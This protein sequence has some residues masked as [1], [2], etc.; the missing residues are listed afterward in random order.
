MYKDENVNTIIEFAPYIEFGSNIQHDPYNRI[1]SNKV[2]I[3][4]IEI[5]SHEKN[6]SGT[7]ITMS[8]GDIHNIALNYNSFLDIYNRVIREY[9]GISIKDDIVTIKNE[10]TKLSFDINDLVYIY[11]KEGP[12]EL[13]FANCGGC[14]IDSDHDILS[15]LYSSWKMKN[16]KKESI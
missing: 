4:I 1:H 13:S 10:T 2:S 12:L 15:K 7:L 8:N 9:R 14:Y 6:K 3:D 16:G 5:A 11:Q